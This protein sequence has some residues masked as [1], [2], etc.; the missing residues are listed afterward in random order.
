MIKHSTE[1]FQK[2]YHDGL[3]AFRKQEFEK[4]Q[5]YFTKAIGLDPNNIQLY[6][7]RAA[8]REKLGQLTSALQDAEIMMNLE[9]TS[10]KGYL[11]AGKLYRLLGQND[12]ALDIY[13]MGIK[14]VKQNDQLLSLLHKLAKEMQE[15]LQ[16]S[17]VNKSTKTCDLVVM[18]PTEL[19]HWIFECLPLAS[20]CKA[21]IVSK[22]WRNFIINS[23]CLWRNLDF[24]L[25]RSEVTDRVVSTYVNRGKLQIRKFICHNAGKLSDKTL[26]TFRAVPCYHL[27]TFELNFNTTIT[28]TA[29]VIF[30]RTIGLE[31][32]IIDFSNTHITDRAVRTILMH[33]SQLETLKLSVCTKITSQAFDLGE[34]QCKAL[35]VQDIDLN[36]CQWINTTV[37]SFML[38]LFPNITRLN[39]HGISGITTRTL[40]DLAHFSNLESISMFGN[41]YEDGLCIENAFIIF[42]SACSLLRQFVLEECPDLTDKCVLYL[43][44]SCINLE[45]LTLNGSYKLTDEATQHIGKHCKQLKVLRIGKSPGITDS[46]INEMLDLGFGSLLEIIELK[47]NNITDNSLKK[48]AD[49]CVNLK[50]VNVNWCSNIT[51]CGVAY[52]VKKCGES[53]KYLSMVDCFNV[54]P[55][56]ADLARKVLGQHGGMV[57]YLFRALR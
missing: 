36:G 50:E 46:G 13:N 24:T 6:D 11:R 27:K 57:N 2:H 25:N 22:R 19:A 17:T 9:K 34:G 14:E 7:S 29:I 56:A 49:C 33:C 32:K 54:A 37:V 21:S 42:T 51:G 44:T 40:A 41:M 30:I 5:T 47:Q 35:A 12:M 39:I 23:Q 18:L 55:D 16:K 31:L 10:A 1:S 8:T 53:M 48:L 38:I 20:I 45:E 3:A 52:L 15:K 4:A 43:V 28:E 26:K